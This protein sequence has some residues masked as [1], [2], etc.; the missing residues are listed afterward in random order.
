MHGRHRSTY[1][2]LKVKKLGPCDLRLEVTDD[3]HSS[4]LATL[5]A[6]MEQLHSEVFDISWRAS[7]SLPRP[8]TRP[9]L[10]LQDFSSEK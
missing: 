10:V 8:F 4:A 3:I 9:S 6:E 7:Y 2:A 5:V 1:S